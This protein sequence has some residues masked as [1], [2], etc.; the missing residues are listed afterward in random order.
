MNSDTDRPK[1]PLSEFKSNA[2][3]IEWI[4]KNATPSAA[5]RFAGPMHL[6]KVPPDQVRQT[7]PP[8]L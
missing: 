8:F 7:L 4:I 1:K 3:Y 6:E 2:E 5:E